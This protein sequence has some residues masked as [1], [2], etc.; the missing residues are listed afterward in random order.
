MRLTNARAAGTLGNEAD[1]V[2]D[3]VALELD[4]ARSPAH[5]LRGAARHALI[6]RLTALDAELLRAVRATMDKAQQRALRQEAED[7]LAGFRSTMA[8]EAF[9]RARDA[10]VDRLVRD[11]Y[12][13]PTLTFV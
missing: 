8:P 1:R 5:C 9:V 2:I 4:A 12:G 7:E 13:L 3:Q 6:E 10:A 11:R